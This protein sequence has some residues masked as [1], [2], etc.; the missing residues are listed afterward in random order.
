VRQQA[1]PYSIVRARA[2]RTELIAQLLGSPAGGRR[3][4]LLF[5]PIGQF[6]PRS[7]WLADDLAE[8]NLVQLCDRTVPTSGN[9]GVRWPRNACPVG[10]EILRAWRA[11]PDGPAARPWLRRCCVSLARQ[12]GPRIPE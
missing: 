11:V 10:R 3:A 8:S 12:R 6:A 5:L 1:F 2:V 4:G 7:R 9:A